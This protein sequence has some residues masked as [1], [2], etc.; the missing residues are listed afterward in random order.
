LSKS[1][2]EDSEEEVTEKYSEADSEVDDED[3][4]EDHGEEYGEGDGKD[5]DQGI[6][7]SS[8]RYPAHIILHQLLKAPHEMKSEEEVWGESNPDLLDYSKPNWMVD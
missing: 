4:G 1:L 7:L 5:E 6:V 2:E 8:P 3:H